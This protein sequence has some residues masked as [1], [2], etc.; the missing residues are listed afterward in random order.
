[1][2]TRTRTSPRFR[3]RARWPSSACRCC[4][5]A[6]SAAARPDTPD[7]RSRRVVLRRRAPPGALFLSAPPQRP[8]PPSRVRRRELDRRLGSVGQGACTR[9]VGSSTTSSEVDMRRSTTRAAW[10]AATVLLVTA[11]GELSESEQLA[12]A[13]A[14]L[15]KADTATAIVQIK[16]ALGQNLNAPLGRYLL[17]KA[18]LESGNLRRCGRSN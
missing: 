1:M 18:L 2:P 8:R 13:Q 6:R 10:L 15:D 9:T 11:C 4:R 16:S 5:S 14:S 12:A 3:S 7:A 17:G